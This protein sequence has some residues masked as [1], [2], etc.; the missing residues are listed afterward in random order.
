MSICIGDDHYRNY[1]EFIHNNS[2]NANDVDGEFGYALRGLS[3]EGGGFTDQVLE[4]LHHWLPWVTY[5]ELDS[6]SRLL[7]TFGAYDIAGCEM[8]PDEEK[9]KRNKGIF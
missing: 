5:V 1:A 4:T 6:T 2:R 9:K 7:D 3:W 8:L